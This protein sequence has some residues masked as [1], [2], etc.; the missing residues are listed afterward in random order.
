MNV[1][2]ERLRLEI[3]FSQPPLSRRSHAAGTGLDE[4]GVPHT[5]PQQT[6]EQE[7]TLSLQVDVDGFLRVDSTRI[8]EQGANLP[9]Q[10]DVGVKPEET[11]TTQVAA[12]QKF[13]RL[14]K[15]RQQR[16]V[17]AWGTEKT[18]QFDPGG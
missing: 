16:G 2:V 15:K 7:G 6:M 1:E 5:V 12:C 3:L 11:T 8:P 4:S 9:S 10:A 13:A 17:T 18:K 14:L